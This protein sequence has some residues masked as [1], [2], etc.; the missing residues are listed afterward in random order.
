MLTGRVFTQKGEYGKLFPDILM[1]DSTIEQRLEDENACLERVK[2]GDKDAYGVIVKNYMKRAYYIALNF[3]KTEQ[4]AMDI[5]Q[6]A[7]I[8]AFRY[9]K[10]FKTGHPFFPWF[11]RLLKNLCLDWLKKNKVRSEIPLE[12]TKSIGSCDDVVEIKTQVWDGIEKLPLEQREIIILR[13]FHGFSYK[14]IASILAKPI[15]SIM[16][17]LYYAKQNLRK[18]MEKD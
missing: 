11:Y 18:I 7:F 16:S 17:N 9:I 6:E 3:V 10:K 8:K 4:D 1:K 2:K 5:S 13:Y 15:G 14:E 12:D